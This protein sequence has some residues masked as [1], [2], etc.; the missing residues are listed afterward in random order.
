MYERTLTTLPETGADAPTTQES[1]RSWIAKQHPPSVCLVLRPRTRSTPFLSDLVTFQSL[2]IL[3]PG[4]LLPARLPFV[5]A[6]V[7]AQVSHEGVHFDTG[8]LGPSIA[9]GNVH[10]MHLLEKNALQHRLN[11]VVGD[12]AVVSGLVARC[13]RVEGAVEYVGDVHGIFGYLML[14]LD[15]EADQSTDFEVVPL[16]RSRT[17]SL[18]LGQV[19]RWGVGSLRHVGGILI[20]MLGSSLAW[21]EG[22]VRKEI[23]ETVCL[24]SEAR[25]VLLEVEKMK[26]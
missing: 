3:N 17:R 8:D 21:F 23:C 25:Q 7:E 11:L 9:L 1:L 26:W 13:S 16:V 4:L 15:D 22:S 5:F 14:A 19:V 2:V 24:R 12:V 18:R 20:L 6:A 10:R